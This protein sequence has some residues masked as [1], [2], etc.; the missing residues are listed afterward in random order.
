[1]IKTWREDLST[2]PLSSCVTPNPEQDI[3]S[4]PYLCIW[5]N[6]APLTACGECWNYEPNK[7]VHVVKC[8]TNRGYSFIH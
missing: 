8:P 6:T 2:P 7:A 4:V 1:M 5:L 3:E